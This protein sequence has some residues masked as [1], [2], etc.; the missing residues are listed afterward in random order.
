[1]KINAILQKSNF[2]EFII[3]LYITILHNLVIAYYLYWYIVAVVVFQ[4]NFKHYLK[5]LAWFEILL[6]LFVD[7]RN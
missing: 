1:M 2:Q 3:D 5:F 6:V 4:I 7:F